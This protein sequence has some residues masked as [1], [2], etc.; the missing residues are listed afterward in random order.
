[1]EYGESLYMGCLL[2][3]DSAFCSYIFHLLRTHYGDSIQSV[4]DLDLTDTL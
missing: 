1:M 3:E 4:G 2:L